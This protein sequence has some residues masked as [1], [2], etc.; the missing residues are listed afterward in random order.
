MCLIDV[1]FVFNKVCVDSGFWIWNIDIFVWLI[2]LGFVFLW[3]FCS[4]VKK[5]NIGVFGKF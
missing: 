2:G 1:G 3:I 4:V 5:V